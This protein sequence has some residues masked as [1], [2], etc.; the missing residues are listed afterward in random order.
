MFGA[1]DG[2]LVGSE[3]GSIVAV[4]VGVGVGVAGA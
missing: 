2:S 4:G 3:D 1:W